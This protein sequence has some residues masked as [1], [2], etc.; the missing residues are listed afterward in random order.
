MFSVTQILTAVSY[1]GRQFVHVDTAKVY[2]RMGVKS[3][4]LILVAVQKIRKSV[5][6]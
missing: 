4:N 1:S 3:A 6:M 5:L 2:R